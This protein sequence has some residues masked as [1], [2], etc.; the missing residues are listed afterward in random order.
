MSPSSV[1]RRARVVAAVLFLLI[2][3]V[4]AAEAQ[5]GPMGF[6]RGYFTPFIATTTGGEVTDPSLTFG[7]SVSVHEQNGWGA[8]VDFGH[9]GDV[10]AGNLELDATTYMVNASWVR[11]TGSI[12]PFGL[13]GAGVMQLDGCGSCNQ[14]SRT[15][16]FG[17]NAGG[18][19]TALLNDIVAVRGDARYFFSAADHADL[20]RPDNFSFWRVSV[21]VT[22]MWV[23]VP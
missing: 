3:R 4:P 15:Y 9:S 14:S 5:G 8:E 7:A 16:D 2:A 18:G 22:L 10:E 1:V 19:V 23:I 20:Q 17:W 6:F 11:P 13:A 21:G 12:R